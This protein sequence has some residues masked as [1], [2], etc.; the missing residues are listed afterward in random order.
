[1]LAA[2]FEGAASAEPRQLLLLYPSASPEATFPEPEPGTAA[3]RL[4]LVVLDG[5]WRKTRKMMHLNPELRQLPRLSLRLPAPSAY[6]IRRAHAPHQLSTLEA[7]AAA[8][9]ALER[10]SRKFQPLLAAF[11]SFV[12]Q[13]QACLPPGWRR[14]RHQIGL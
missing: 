13:Q 6:L 7:T 5:T 9:G 12:K 2:P 14:V 8:L 10:D 1:V 4:R 3:S 11:D